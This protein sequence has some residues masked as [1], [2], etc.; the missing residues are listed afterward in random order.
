MLTALGHAIQTGYTEGII[1]LFEEK[2][3]EQLLK[4]V[5]AE[6]S[7]EHQSL[8]LLQ[9]ILRLSQDTTTEMADLYKQMLDWDQSINSSNW[10]DTMQALLLNDSIRTKIEHLEHKP[11]ASKKI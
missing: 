2:R 3:A 9:Q 1:V 10:I 4:C 7:E 6:N 8:A 5:V 11:R